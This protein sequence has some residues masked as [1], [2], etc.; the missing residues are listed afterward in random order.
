[1]KRFD[2]LLAIA[3]VGAVLVASRPASAAEVGCVYNGGVHTCVWYPGYPYAAPPMAAYDYG[4]G[5]LGALGAIA[6]APLTVASDVTAPLMTGR[7]VAVSAPV[8]PGVAGPGNYCGTPVRTCLLREPGWLGTGCS[9][10]VYGGRAR[11]FVE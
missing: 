4:L 2:V 1:M 10:R 11:G 7:S 3:I 6:T 5:G 8:A 9:C